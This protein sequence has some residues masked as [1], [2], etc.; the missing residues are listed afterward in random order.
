M[1]IIF[2]ASGGLGKYIFSHFNSSSQ[3]IGTYKKNKT[4]ED[5]VY[6]DILKLGDCINVFKLANKAKNIT[7]INATGHSYNSIFH[8]ADVD[9]WKTSLDINVTGA[10]NVMRA[11]IEYMI[12]NAGGRIINLSSIVGQI[13]VAGTSSYSA[14][15]S[16]L[17]GLTRT[18][19]REYAS[20]KIFI[21][22]LNLGYFDRGMIDLVP[23]N[24]KNEIRN[25]IPVEEF[26]HP[27]EII[28]AINWLENSNYVT[29]TSI[30]I[31]GGLL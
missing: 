24:L 20:R 27:S 16:A 26:G 4:H 12:G 13:P 17:T 7:V 19:A 5:L 29:G 8:R 22:N 10:H 25:A 15:K 23:S 18:L 28:N 21:N 2:G 31:N 30:D 3:C 11:S 6:C 9:L 1:K 14:S